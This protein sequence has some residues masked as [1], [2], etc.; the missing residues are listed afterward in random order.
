MLLF[1]QKANVYNEK[2]RHF[3][4]LFFSL[5]NYRWPEKKWNIFWCITSTG[6]SLKAVGR[7]T[8]PEV[9]L[10]EDEEF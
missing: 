7:N 5:E 2:C 10:L 1:P 4:S 6:I 9:L 3:Y 8:V